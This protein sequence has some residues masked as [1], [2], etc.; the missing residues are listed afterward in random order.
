MHQMDASGSEYLE[1][2]EPLGD[3]DWVLRS[4]VPN[5][6]GKNRQAQPQRVWLAGLVDDFSGVG[7]WQYYV[8]PGESASWMRRFLLQVWEG[9]HPEIVLRGMP[10]KLYTDNGPFAKNETTIAFLSERTGLGVE[11]LKSLPYNKRAHGKI[12][13]TWRTLWQTFELGFLAHRGE[14]RLSELN[15]R[16][17]LDF[18]LDYQGK[19]HRTGEGTRAEMYLSHLQGE[20]RLPAQNA[21]QSAFRVFD[22]RID[23]NGLFQFGGKTYA[24]AKEARDAFREMRALVYQNAQNQICVENVLTGGIVKA[25]IWEGAQAIGDFE[26]FPETAAERAGKARDA[27]KFPEVSLYWG[28]RAKK[29][30]VIEMP[31]GGRVYQEIRNP[32]SEKGDPRFREDDSESSN[33]L[34]YLG[35]QREENRSPMAA[36]ERFASEIE[37]RKFIA[38]RLGMGL[39]ELRAEAPLLMG[40]IE[41]LVK[42][43]LDKERITAWCEEIPGRLLKAIGGNS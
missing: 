16:F 4:R 43:T 10:E 23:G 21:Q 31:E 8:A 11:H 37:A 28:D 22:R 17:L 34:R 7:A 14:I 27:G 9:L 26:S 24:V 15:E 38:V 29:P 39:L 12:E 25:E 41:E 13:R 35:A 18:I 5:R 6:R 1:V 2:V 32:K 33:V 3:D 40:E 20:I 30:F 42:E 19:K 36:A